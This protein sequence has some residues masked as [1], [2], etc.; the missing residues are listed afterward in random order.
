MRI[1]L[2]RFSLLA[3]LGLV[4]AAPAFPGFHSP[5]QAQGVEI[6]PGGVRI[7]PDRDYRRG[8]RW[9][10]SE[11]EAVRIARRYGILDVDRV[12]R[13]ERE[14]RVSGVDRRGR[15]IRVVIDARTGDITRVVQRR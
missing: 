1:S 15:F 12:V 4:L 9:R 14:W 6:G 11:R 2:S 7:L 8:P 10:V 3:A 13:T 5:A